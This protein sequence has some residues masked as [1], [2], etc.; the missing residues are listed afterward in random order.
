MRDI[1]TNILDDQSV[2]SD[3]LFDL[4][5]GAMLKARVRSWDP[6]LEMGLAPCTCYADKATRLRYQASFRMPPRSNAGLVPNYQRQL[7]A[8]M[9]EPFVK[10]KQAP[11]HPMLKYERA[12]CVDGS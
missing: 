5:F 9:I 10:M 7:D 11:Q 6:T 2:W 4:D 12:L 1:I 8:P 3:L